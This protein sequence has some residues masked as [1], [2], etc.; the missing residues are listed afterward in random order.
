VLIKFSRSFAPLAFCAF[1]INSPSSYSLDENY[2]KVRS[3]QVSLIEEDVLNQQVSRVIQDEEFPTKSARDDFRISPY[4]Y[5]QYTDPAVDQVGRVIVIAKDLVALGESIYHLVQKGKPTVK[6][7]Y[8]PISVIPRVDGKHVDILDMENWSMPRRL[9]YEVEY[10]NYYGMNVVKFRY[11][12]IFS[13]SGSFNGKGA[14]LT[15]T[16]IIPES[17]EV[18]WGYDFSAQMKLGGI[19]NMGTKQSPIAAAILIMEYQ[20]ETVFRSEVTA[21]SYFVTGK[22]GYRQL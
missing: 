10:K 1:L 3:M 7:T 8:A 17:V 19:Q 21:N 20:V 11:S 13:H 18:S 4:G 2:F 12:I 6:T 22:G 15:S 14:Y 9:S 16:Q 5:G